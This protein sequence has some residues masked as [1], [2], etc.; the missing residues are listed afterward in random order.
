[1]DYETMS[2]IV[3]IGIAIAIIGSILKIVLG[4]APALKA[5]KSVKSGQKMGSNIP[6]IL[7]N[8]PKGD[9]FVDNQLLLDVNQRMFNEQQLRD[10]SFMNQMMFDQQMQ[11]NQL[12][13]DQQNQMNQSFL[14]E[15]NNQAWMD[16]TSIANGGT[17][18]GLDLTEH[19]HMSPDFGNTFGTGGGFD[20]FGGMGG[21]GF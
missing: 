5:A 18:F 12:M 4:L 7:S 8:A 14:N 10:S 9:F 16:N 13:L 21:M 20:N 15:M 19:S 2:I 6:L 3:P 11:M 17:N 1:M